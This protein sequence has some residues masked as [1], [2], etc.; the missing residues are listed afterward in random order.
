MA[1]SG[2]KL[3]LLGTTG[4][5]A[6]LTLVPSLAFA[7][8]G[9]GGVAVGLDLAAPVVP[10]NAITVPDVNALGILDGQ[11]P[12]LNAGLWA[13]EFGGAITKPGQRSNL[14]MLG[15]SW[16]WDMQVGG[17]GVQA[18]ASCHYHAGADNRKT[19]QVTP[20][21]KMTGGGPDIPAGDADYLHDLF[22]APNATLSPAQYADTNVNGNPVGLPVDELALIA[23]GSTADDLDGTTGEPGNKPLATDDV[24]DGVSSQGVRFG[25]FDSITQIEV[26]FDADDFG[27]AIIPCTVEEETFE[28]SGVFETVANTAVLSSYFTSGRVDTAE[29]ALSDEGFTHAFTNFGTVRRV[30]PRNSPTVLNSVYHMRNFWD[31]R[32]DMFFNGINPLGFRDPDAMVKTYNGSAVV[33]T[34]LRIPFSSLASQA[35]GPIESNFEMVFDGRPHRELGRKLLAPG[36]VPLAGQAVSTTDS[37]L[38]G[39]VLPGGRGLDQHYEDWIKA[40]FDERFWGDGAGGDV[41][42]DASGA[43]ALCDGS[44]AYTLMEWNFSL[45]FGLAVQAYEALLTT[46]QTIVDLQV[47]GIATGTVTNITRDNR[48]RIRAQV[49]VPV[50]GLPLA[51]CI[52][53]AALNNNAAQAAV[54]T[55]LCMQHYGQFIHPLATSGSQSA[56]TAT[57]IPAST[58]IGGCNTPVLN[59]VA[60]NGVV[61]TAW[62]GTSDVN[63]V[64]AALTAIDRGIGRFF[65]GATGCAICHFNPEFT[66][67]TVAALTGFGAAPPPPLPP[68]QVRRVPLE[69][70]MERMIAFNGAPAVYDAGFYNLGVRPTPED[71]SL[72]DA[73]G[74]VPLAFSKLAE[75][76][77]LLAGP[78]VAAPYDATKIAAISADLGTTLMIPTSATDLTPIPWNLALACGPGLVGIGNG[79]GNNNPNAQCVPTVVPGERLLRN[80]AFKAQG[81]RNVKYTGPYFHNGSKMDLMQAVHFYE[82]A[83]SFTT[84][85]L[86]N[87]DAGLRIFN[88]GPTDTAAL[89]E[90]ME[91]GLTDWRLAHEQGKF[92]HPEICV[93]HG[94]DATSGDTI[95][96]GIPAV[97]SGGNA[98]P[99]QTFEEQLNGD[100]AHAHN[101]AQPCT[102]PDISAAGLSTIELPPAPVPA[103]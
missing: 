26:C 8:R 61:Q 12:I 89:V 7:Q 73:I 30:E 21:V 95:L 60:E 71:I 66:G 18:C 17:D 69:V 45:F 82:T 3:Q 29:L 83:G 35:V 98:A 19:H 31:G 56:A 1:T 39:L 11:G 78:G 27:G 55:Q 20:G 74:G 92:D 13:V 58:P 65:A 46:E 86:N 42:L 41:C 87:L 33:D 91:T 48:G 32:A 9:G 81:L 6:A 14:Q 75:Q 97:G 100:L 49:V 90:M 70:P 36:V 72:G 51:G 43:G 96:V 88:L 93:P 76:I 10:L 57:P 16:F 53:A 50:T 40:V 68:G 2:K 54:A 59:T 47:G 34:K 24:N 79:N 44:E 37:L 15:K 101:L 64:I 23:G 62:C 102:V 99:L 22:G 5:L 25:T 94:H 4:I 77:Q 103:P 84:L 85:N 38:G 28:G 67:A 80:G 52:A 63:S